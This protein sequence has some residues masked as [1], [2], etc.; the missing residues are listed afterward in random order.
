MLSFRNKEWLKQNKP[1][2]Q[3]L[4]TYMYPDFSDL[5]FTAP[6]IFGIVKCKMFIIVINCGNCSHFHVLRVI[7]Y[8]HFNLNKLDVSGWANSDEIISFIFACFRTCN[9]LIPLSRHHVQLNVLV[10]ILKGPFDS[11][12]HILSILNI[13]S[14]LSPLN[15]RKSCIFRDLVCV[16]LEVFPNENYL[17]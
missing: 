7:K 14:T 15:E 6:I 1:N 10:T 11:A 12:F 9:K 3:R 5:A 17:K 16:L 2:V 8:H 13:Y 4:K